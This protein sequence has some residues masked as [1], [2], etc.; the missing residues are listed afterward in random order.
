MALEPCPPPQ[1]GAAGLTALLWSILVVGI[2]GYALF[3]VMMRR[4]PAP[5][6]AALQLLAPPLA[7]LF[8][9]ALLGER[10]L[11]ADL[12]GGAGTLAGIALLLRARGG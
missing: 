5:T 10:L 6:A 2:G 12:A 7:A 3:F 8:D 1:I 4:L 11:P 9:W